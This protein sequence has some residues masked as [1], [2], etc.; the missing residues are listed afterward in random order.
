MT[1]VLAPKYTKWAWGEPKGWWCVTHHLQNYQGCPQHYKGQFFSFVKVVGRILKVVWKQCPPFSNRVTHI[2]V[3]A[4]LKKHQQAWKN[5]TT[6]P[7][8][9]LAYLG[10]DSD[11]GESH[12][13]QEDCNRCWLLPKLQLNLISK[14]S[15]PHIQMTPLALSHIQMT[16][17]PTSSMVL[18]QRKGNLGTS[19]IQQF[20]SIEYNYKFAIIDHQKPKTQFS[21]STIPSLEQ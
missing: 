14:S 11:I 18:L 4:G 6:L 8:G 3:S 12:Q 15:I 9:D 10:A 19:C 16:I 1:W 20:N 2:S 17:Y 5:W 13:D 21:I 7:R